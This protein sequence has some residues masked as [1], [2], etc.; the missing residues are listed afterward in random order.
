MLVVSQPQLLE[1]K[2]VVRLHE[3]DALV[4]IGRS[5]VAVFLGERIE[6]CAAG[7]FAGS[8]RTR[9]SG[10]SAAAKARA[11]GSRCPETS[12]STSKGTRSSGGRA[13]ASASLVT[14]DTTAGIGIATESARCAGVRRS[15]ASAAE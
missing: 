3:A 1:R 6:R 11:C 2:L 13:E 12:S 10:A 7:T 8:R 4:V 5:R 9:E 15:E 14:E